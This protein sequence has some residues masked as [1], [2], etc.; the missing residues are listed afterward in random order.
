MAAKKAKGD[1]PE[2]RMQAL[3]LSGLPMPALRA[4]LAS[5]AAY[6][7]HRPS[8]GL[9]D[10]QLRALIRALVPRG[11]Q[12]EFYKEVMEE[13]DS[14]CLVSDVRRRHLYEAHDAVSCNAAHEGQKVVRQMTV[15]NRLCPSRNAFGLAVLKLFSGQSLKRARYIMDMCHALARVDGYSVFLNNTGRGRGK[16]DDITYVYLARTRDWGNSWEVA[17]IDALDSY[18]FIK[19]YDLTYTGL[20]KC[21]VGAQWEPLEIETHSST[22][23]RELVEA[24]RLA[25]HDSRD[26]LDSIDGGVTP[27]HDMFLATDFVMTAEEV[28]DALSYEDLGALRKNLIENKAR[29]DLCKEWCAHTK[30][31]F[32]ELRD[33][34]ASQQ[35]RRGR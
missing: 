30:L 27:L 33:D 14:Q 31:D 3:A 10:V 13:R 23:P 18:N 16:T 7:Y 19:D 26:V 25:F 1:C 22:A 32:N 5:K 9:N 15:W 8:D 29:I 20:H 34:Y 2:V 24:I 35:A 12:R 28:L 17:K 11:S 6:S 4:R 21:L